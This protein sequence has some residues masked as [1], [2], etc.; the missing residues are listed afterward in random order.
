MPFK[1]NK[2]VLFD[3]HSCCFC[4]IL[5]LG[6]IW[7][8]L[9]WIWICLSSFQKCKTFLSLSSTFS[10]A[11]TRSLLSFFLFPTRA[12]LFL[13]SFPLLQPNRPVSSPRPNPAVTAHILRAWINPKWLGLREQKGEETRETEEKNEGKWD[14]IKFGQIRP[15]LKTLKILHVELSEECQTVE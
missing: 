5:L 14:S 8:W 15:N 9:S 13:S 2:V 11:Q 3:L 7:I 4:I 6:S 1:L 10:P 12:L